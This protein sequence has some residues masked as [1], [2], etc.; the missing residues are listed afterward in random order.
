MIKKLRL[1]LGSVSLLIVAISVFTLTTE[2]ESKKEYLSLDE[3]RLQHAKVVASSPFKETLTWDKKK[4][5]QAGLPPNRYFEQMWELSINPSTGKLDNDELN[6]IRE[7]LIA[8]DV[9]THFYNSFDGRK[10]CYRYTYD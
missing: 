4:R 8:R 9:Y 5:K 6:I 7:N 10:T 2:N 1:L 3:Q